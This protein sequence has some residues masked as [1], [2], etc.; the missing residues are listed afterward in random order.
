[1]TRRDYGHEMEPMKLSL[2]I[3]SRNS[4]AG[5]IA[6]LVDNPHYA[7]RAQICI[8]E[9]DMP[10]PMDCSHV[11]FVVVPLNREDYYE[12]RSNMEAAVTSN[13]ARQPTLPLVNLPL[14][15]RISLWDGPD[16]SI[17]QRDEERY[18]RSKGWQKTSILK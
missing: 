1:M 17:L 16:T 11:G 2:S 15:S 18:G 8:S 7:I 6:E 14:K 3:E 10:L 5:E 12:Y 13:L 4:P 9:F